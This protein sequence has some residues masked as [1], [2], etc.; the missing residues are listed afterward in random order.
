VVAFAVNH[1][2]A[3]EALVADIYAGLGI[4]CEVRVLPVHQ[5]GML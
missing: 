2:C 5:K 4:P 1:P 3:I